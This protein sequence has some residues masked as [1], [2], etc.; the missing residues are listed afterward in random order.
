MIYD[1]PS[2]PENKSMIIAELEKENAELRKQLSEYK[3]AVYNLQDLLSEVN[4]TD[5]QK[6]FLDEVLDDIKPKK[7]LSLD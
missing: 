6:E 4:L 5:E 3:R 2:P 7:K 1:Y